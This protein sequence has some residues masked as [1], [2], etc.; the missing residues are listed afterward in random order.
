MGPQRLVYVTKY[1]TQMW[2]D[3]SQFVKYDAEQTIKSIQTLLDRQNKRR[4]EEEQKMM[5]ELKQTTTSNPSNLQSLQTAHQQQLANQ[6]DSQTRNVEKRKEVHFQ[7]EVGLGD[8][9]L[10]ELDFPD[11][12][13]T[14]AGRNDRSNCI[15]YLCNK[16]NIIIISW[17]PICQ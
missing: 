5:T 16:N 13:E 14:N 2:V 15:E 10:T 4:E 17:P 1:K 11:N 12:L 6:S 7:D 8:I 9:D 3:E